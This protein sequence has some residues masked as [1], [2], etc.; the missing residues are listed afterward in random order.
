MIWVPSRSRHLSACGE[1]LAVAVST[2]TKPALVL[3]WTVVLSSVGVTWPTIVPCHLLDP[4]SVLSAVSEYRVRNRKNEAS[5]S[6]RQRHGGLS[7]SFLCGLI[8]SPLFG[9]LHHVRPWVFFAQRLALANESRDIEARCHGTRAFNARCTF[10]ALNRRG[11]VGLKS[12]R[13]PGGGLSGDYSPTISGKATTAPWP[14]RSICR[15]PSAFAGVWSG[16]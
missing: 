4:L 16:P 9:F 11:F 10:R 2:R 7:D 3:L 5:T 14:A 1:T 15:K 6:A 13:K 8:G 12:V